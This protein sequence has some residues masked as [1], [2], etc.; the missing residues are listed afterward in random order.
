LP[1]G[2]NNKDGKFEAFVTYC[3]IFLA[4]LI[5]VLPQGVLPSVEEAYDALLRS[6]FAVVVIY[7]A[8][9]G[10]QWKAK[11]EGSQ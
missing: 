1:A 11:S 4:N 5:Y 6:L 3:A 2:V 7:L 10:I 9:K 8:N